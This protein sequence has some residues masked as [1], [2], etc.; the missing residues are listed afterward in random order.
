MVATPEKGV[1]NLVRT[2]RIQ[3]SSTLHRFVDSFYTTILSKSK[4]YFIRNLACLFTQKLSL[5]IRMGTW[6]I[7]RPGILGE[8]RF[9]G[10]VWKVLLVIHICTSLGFWTIRNE[11]FH[12]LTWIF[13][14]N[15]KGNAFKSTL[16]ITF[17][18]WAAAS[19]LAILYC[20]T[21]HFF[22]DYWFSSQFFYFW[23]ESSMIAE[24]LISSFIE[25]KLHCTCSKF[26]REQVV[27]NVHR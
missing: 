19:R 5:L 4:T 1:K 21:I 7:W 12:P 20:M 11:K 6:C 8:L 2:Y 3:V 15:I 25:I 27:V 26:M 14:I 23:L 13:Y 24:H 9:V 22:Q 18:H 10:L 17:N 16:D